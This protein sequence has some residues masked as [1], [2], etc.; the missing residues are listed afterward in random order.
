MTRAI[1]HSS[2]PDASGRFGAYGGRYVPE[3][4]VAALEELDAAYR[5]AKSDDAFQG[6]LDRLL[7]EAG[8][9]RAYFK[10]YRQFKMYNDPALNPQLYGGSK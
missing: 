8:D 6:E 4:L 9:G 7:L 10:V 2:V 3:T 5:A 1:D